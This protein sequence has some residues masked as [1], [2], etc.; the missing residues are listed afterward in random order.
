MT[1]DSP[2]AQVPTVVFFFKDICANDFRVGNVPV[3]LPRLSIGLQ[4]S[5]IFPFEKFL[6]MLGKKDP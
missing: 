2:F 4:M 1:H 3:L 6:R 5:K